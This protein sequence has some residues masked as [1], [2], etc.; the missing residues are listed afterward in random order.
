MEQ[1]YSDGG[2]EKKSVRIADT[3]LMCKNGCEFFG[4]PAWQG[5]CSMCWRDQQRAKADISDS[6]MVASGT[7]SVN[8]SPSH[9]EKLKK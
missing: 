7:G 8:S 4:N 9:A 6:G 2:L 3:Q 5:Y 1:S